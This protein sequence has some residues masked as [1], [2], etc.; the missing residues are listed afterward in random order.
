MRVAA[1]AFL[2]FLIVGCVKGTTDFSTLDSNSIPQPLFSGA[3]SKDVRVT[4]L[5]QEVDLEGTCDFKISKIT[6][7]TVGVMAQSDQLSNIGVSGATLKCQSSPGTFS[8]RLKS[9]TALGFT[10][11]ENVPVEIHLR[12]VTSAG[13]SRVTTIRL[14]YSNPNGDGPK[15]MVLTSGSTESGS[16]GQRIAVSDGTAAY[17]ATIR[18]DHRINRMDSENMNTQMKTSASYRAVIGTAAR[19]H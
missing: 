17:R 1:V 2:S 16:T 12:G 14:T 5:D 18:V 15:G 9:L 3:T 13:V 11:S 6:A 10:P 4:S 7:Q 8:F 19:S